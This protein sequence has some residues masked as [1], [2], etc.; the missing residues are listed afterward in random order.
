MVNSLVKKDEAMKLFFSCLMIVW[1]LNGCSVKHQEALATVSYLSLEAYMGAWYEIARYENRFEK[2]CVGARAEYR[3]EETLLHV[4]NR[5][6]DEK[7]NEIRQAKGKAYVLENSGN[8]KLKVSFFW[9]F[10]GDYWVLML[11]DDY[12][13]AVVGEPSREYLW[14]LSRTKVLSEEDLK[15]IKTQLPSLGYDAS[16]L[17]FTRE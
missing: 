16:K 2:G 8:A 7:G 5:C 15:A 13:Y 9:P 3:I 6:F 14:I 11:A 12:R 10:Y 17:Y 4:T 1:I